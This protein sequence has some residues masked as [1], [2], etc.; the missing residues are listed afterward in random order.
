MVLKLSSYSDGEDTKHPFLQR[1]FDNSQQKVSDFVIQSRF[2]LGTSRGVLS[3]IKER[4]ALQVVKAAP[5]KLSKVV[6]PQR[7][8]T[9]LT[10]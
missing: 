10:W 9:A 5:V 4:R 3:I 8:R 2:D 6:R 1:E 7:D